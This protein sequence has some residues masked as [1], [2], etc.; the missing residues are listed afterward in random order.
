M[1]RSNR[2]LREGL[3]LGG[4]AYVT[5]AIFYA[6]FDV[7]AARGFLYTVDLLGKALFHGLRDPSVLALPIQ[8]DPTGIFFYNGLHFVASLVIGVIV[9]GLIARA[10]RG[11]TEA[12][13]SLVVIVA[14]FFLTVAV[15]QGLTVPIRALLPTWSIVTANGVATLVAG[16]ALVWKRPEVVRILIPILGRPSIAR[17]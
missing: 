12:Y 6:V 10:E 13:L 3:M 4:I 14:G 7:L 8:V 16:S 11:P 1:T 9:A 5:V 2:T 17:S 15:V